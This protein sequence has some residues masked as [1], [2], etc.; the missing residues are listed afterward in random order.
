MYYNKYKIILIFFVLLA[1]LFSGTDGTIRGQ[2]VDTEGEPVIGAQVVIKK[3]GIGTAADL[4]GN[5]LLLKCSCRF[6]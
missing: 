3:N 6:I 2:I 1:S 4:D 5:Y